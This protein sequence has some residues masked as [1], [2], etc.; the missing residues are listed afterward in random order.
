MIHSEV[1]YQASLAYPAALRADRDR[2]LAVSV[3]DELAREWV[4]G[5]IDRALA[6]VDEELAEYQ[7]SIAQLREPSKA[8]QA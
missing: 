3:L 2:A 4:I 5:G 7:T 1:E 8:S 6:A